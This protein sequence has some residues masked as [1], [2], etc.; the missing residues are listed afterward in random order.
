MARISRDRIGEY[1]YTAL[2]VVA[3]NEGVLP[4]GEVIKQTGTRLDLNDYELEQL[5]KSGYV[6]WTSFLHFNS[7]MLT[8]AGW[9]RKEGG[10]WYVTAEG[11]TALALGQEEF[12]KKGRAA[13]RSWKKQQGSDSDESEEVEDSEEIDD[14]D[15]TR[16]LT[17]EQA[18][19]IVDNDTCEATLLGVE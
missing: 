16:L 17:Y 3:D 2:Q 8:K 1:V 5:E 6:R 14:P 9:V 18:L 10:K 19:G 7:V 12:V 13:Y 11:L 4:S 15:V